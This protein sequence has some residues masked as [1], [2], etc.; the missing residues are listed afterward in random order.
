MSLMNAFGAFQ[1]I[2]RALDE[3]VGEAEGLGEP[4]LDPVQDS[5][6]AR[7]AVGV[8]L[9]GVAAR[10]AEPGEGQR[11]VALERVLARREPERDAALALAAVDVAGDDHVVPLAEP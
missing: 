1:P 2:Q 9:A 7:G 5:L 11:L 4:A 3:V 8:V 10:C 6:L